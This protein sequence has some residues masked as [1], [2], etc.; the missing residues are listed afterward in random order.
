MAVEESG[1]LIFNHE[2]EEE[3]EDE[4]ETERRNAETEKWITYYSSF[5][6]ILLVGEGDF[7]FSSC[8]AKAFGS[9]SNI[10]ATSLD[11]YDM[12]IKKYKDAK[13]NLESLE[14]LGA[15]LML[16]V[17][18]T[19]MK[20]FSDLQMRKFDRIIYN[21]PH[22]GFYGKEDHVCLIKMHR[23]LLQ[24]FFKNASHMLRPFGE[25]HVNHKTTP[26]FNNWNLEELASKHNLVLIECVD[27]KKQDYPGYN[28]KRGAGPKCDEPFPLGKC[29]TFK[30]GF[31]PY[32]KKTQLKTGSDYI[33]TAPYQ[34]QRIAP[35]IHNPVPLKISYPTE[36]PQVQGIPQQTQKPT[37]S[38]ISYPTG[39]PQVQGIPPQTQNPTTFDVS[40]PSGL[41]QIRGIWPQ[42]QNLTPFD[43]SYPQRDCTINMS[44]NL[45]YVDSLFAPKISDECSRIFDGYVE[46]TTKMF[47]RTGYHVGQVV[48]ETLRNGFQR[49][50]VEAPGRTIN[51]YIMHLEELHRFS[52]L[53]SA[54]LR[55]MLVNLEKQKM[56]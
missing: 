4:D 30:F 21:F 29:S 33:H 55:R 3:E 10:V 9:A 19:K 12:V 15:T 20:L 16:G 54:W 7:S 25:V 34:I 45:G 5:H 8:L 56:E 32:V 6:Q 18:A 1:R 48:H 44:R 38:N 53:R 24:G 42:T 17:D 14:K 51:G 40:Y 11:Q 37:L 2:E 13:S 49:Y 36:L 23:N 43:T 35:Q 31:S 39:L 52:I 26:P 28:N 47:G 50:M 46:D 27:F 41:H 22:A